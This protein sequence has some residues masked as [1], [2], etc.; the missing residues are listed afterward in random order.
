MVDVYMAR[1]QNFTLATLLFGATLLSACGG[2]ENN[3]GGGGSNPATPFSWQRHNQNPLIV[4]TLTVTTID[5]T[6]A[7]PSVLFDNSDNK[8]KLWFSSSLTNRNNGSNVITIKYSDSADGVTWSTPIVAFQSSADVNAWDHTHAETPAVI[9]NPNVNAPAG[10]KFMMWYSGANTTLAASQ[11]RPTTFP[12]YQIGLAY[13]ADGKSFTRVSPGVNNQPG[14]ALQASAA[15]FGSNLPGNYGDGLLADPEVIYR[16]NSF[17][18]WFSSMAETVPA[19][20]SPVG[21]TP[22]AFGISHATSTDGINWSTSHDNPLSSLRKIGEVASGQQPSVLFNSSSNQYEMWLTNDTAL[23]STLMPCS[24]FQAYGF[25]KAISNDGVNWTPD[26]VSRDFA[27]IPTFSYEAN[28]LFTGVE[29]VRV[30]GEYRAYYTAWS[31][32][33]I[34]DPSLYLC[35]DQFNG[36][37]PAI[38]TLNLAIWSN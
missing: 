6:A 36:F 32:S 33:N 38:S 26:Y 14:L 24:A 29:V 15:L 19:P 23:E 12:Y 1:Q 22:L 21:R 4:P 35:P 37:I 17:H 7:D 25:W 16:N 5:Y 3:D 28:G 20:V 10:E 2:G 11:N 34:P 13:S 31:N 9:K 27:W 30:N 8:W 18:I